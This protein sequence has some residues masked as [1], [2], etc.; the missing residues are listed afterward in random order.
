M[1]GEKM[2]GM[3]RIKSE[4]KEM[5]F[6]WGRGSMRHCSICTT[7]A[8]PTTTTTSTGRRRL[9]VVGRR[10]G[11][12]R[13]DRACLFIAPTATTAAI[14]IAT[15]TTFLA[16]R[17]STTAAAAAAATTTTTAIT[18]TILV[19]MIAEATRR[20]PHLSVG[21]GSVRLGNAAVVSAGGLRHRELLDFVRERGAR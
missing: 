13:G 15:A 4:T 3:G 1:R 18:I 12:P 9:G 17:A 14:T 8:A 5:L 6:T 7:T 11:R 16:F 19:V 20:I 21:L 10:C 2:E